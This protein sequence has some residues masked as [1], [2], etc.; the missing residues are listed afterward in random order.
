MIPVDKYLLSQYSET[1][2]WK[3]FYRGDKRCYYVSDDGEVVVLK[4]QK[5]KGWIDHYGY[6]T[7]TPGKSKKKMKIHRLVAKAFIPNP[8]N[9]AM[10]NHKDGNKKNNK[11]NNLEWCSCKQNNQHAWKTGLKKRRCSDAQ[12]LEAVQLVKNGTPQREAAKK[13]GISY[14]HL[15]NIMIGNKQ[16]EL[17]GIEPKKSKEG[18]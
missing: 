4:C 14:G 18:N 16:S 12:I 3:E 2:K 1:K 8:N 7:I 10:V 5:L 6:P 11:V 13:V 15:A 9:F 17:T